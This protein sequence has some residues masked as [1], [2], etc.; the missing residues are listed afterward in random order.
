MNSPVIFNITFLVDRDT[1]LLRDYADE[2]NMAN[3]LPYFKNFV[4]DIDANSSFTEGF[5][6]AVLKRASAFQNDFHRKNFNAK[7]SRQIYLVATFASLVFYYINKTKEP[8]HIAWISD[9]DAMVDRYDGFIYDLAHFM[10]LG[11]CSNDIPETDRTNK[12]ILDKPQLVF[13]IPE[14]FGENFYDELIR[15]PDYLAGTLADLDINENEFSK[16]KYYT[17]LYHSL[18]NSKNHAIFHV[19]GDSR[20]LSSRRLAHRA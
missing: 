1:K 8:S 3:F 6:D 12:T 2:E 16:D 15:I 5:V 13:P 20:K 9:R 17:V 4:K 10:F 18:M 19:F 7:L 11:E 14:K